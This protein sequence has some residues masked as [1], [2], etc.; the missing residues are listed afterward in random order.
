M[1]MFARRMGV[2]RRFNDSVSTNTAPPPHGACHALDS[3]LVGVLEG[4]AELGHVGE[5]G[6]DLSD[7]GPEVGD[8]GVEVLIR[9]VLAVLLHQLCAFLAARFEKAVD[10]RGVGQFGHEVFDGL[11]ELG[12]FDGLGLEVG[13]ELLVLGGEFGEGGARGELLAQGADL[14]LKRGDEGV[15][16]V[17]IGGR[18]RLVLLLLREEG[19]L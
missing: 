8:A 13:D 15:V 10:L 6:V 9:R 11:F 19:E 18:G 16:F 17:G 5:V 3:S 12:G 1:D 14:F 7:L 4:V 2:W